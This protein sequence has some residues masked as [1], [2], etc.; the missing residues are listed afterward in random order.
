MVSSI[1]VGTIIC[2]IA[3]MAGD[4]S[5]DLKTGYIVGATPKKQ[6]YGELISVV[7]SSMAIGGILYLLNAAWGYGSSELPAPQATLMK[8]VVEGVMGGNLPWNLVFAGVALA[9][10]AEK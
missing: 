2:I 6:Q 4:T 10:A 3:A 8:M 9:V 5:Q 7:V 1:A